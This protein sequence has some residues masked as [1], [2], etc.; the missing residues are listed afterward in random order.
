[1]NNNKK[2]ERARQ[3]FLECAKDSN[4]KSVGEY[5]RADKKV[6]LI[7]PNNHDWEVTP[8]HFRRGV[9]CPKCQNRSSSQAKERF[10]SL[11]KLEGYKCYDE[12][13]GNKV[14]V[15]MECP[16][17]HRYKVRPND[18]T[19]GHRCRSCSI[20]NS[21]E[22]MARK[23]KSKRELELLA[24][25]RGFK[26]LGEYLNLDSKIEMECPK[27]HVRKYNIG[28]F[29]NGFGCPVCSN[30]D[31]IEAEKDFH[32]LLKKEEYKAKS[33][34]TSC[35]E[36]MTCECPEG[37]IFKIRPND[38]KNG[39]RCPKCLRKSYGEEVAV[40]ELIDKNIVFEVEK[41]FDGLIGDGGG[42]LRFD[43]YIPLAKIAIEIQGEH[44]FKNN[45]YKNSFGHDEIKRKYCLDNNIKL[46][47]IEY[48]SSEIGL[49]NAKAKVR[50]EINDIIKNN[51][52][53]ESNK[54]QQN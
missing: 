17:G 43:I 34:Y 38:F 26:I 23:E 46:F 15:E 22:I 51:V 7:C 8:S 6:H 52:Y 9:R 50:K 36:K 10:L 29:K 44:H 20:S 47:E 39:R 13:K 28:H 30:T 5:E 54:P 2:K 14:K 3:E 25:T 41:T 37:H 16:K 21:P 48:L 53:M 35:M 40:K 19:T 12:Y 27:G 11:V 42:K 33:E 1:M 24:K 32:N 31:K 49:N 45:Y 18:F 4:Y